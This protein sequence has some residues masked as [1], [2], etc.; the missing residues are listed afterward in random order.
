MISA[1]V[2][3]V[4]TNVHDRL[5]DVE[6]LELFS[7]PSILLAGTFLYPKL[8]WYE[9]CSS[10]QEPEGSHFGG[11]DHDAESRDAKTAGSAA[12]SFSILARVGT[13]LGGCRGHYAVLVVPLSQTDSFEGL[14]SRGG[15]L[16]IAVGVSSDMLKA[17]VVFRKRREEIA[18]RQ[19]ISMALGLMLLSI[20]SGAAAEVVRVV[21]DHGYADARQPQAA[22]DPSGKIYIVFGAGDAVHCAVSQDGGQ[23][24]GQPVQGR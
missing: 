22:V 4:L 18:M 1:A 8:A 19:Q 7:C 14:F 9:D 23:S 24:Y 17:A 11:H 15:P 16:S 13:F 10:K 12:D 2:G 6:A 3:I 21:P 20:Q 5:R